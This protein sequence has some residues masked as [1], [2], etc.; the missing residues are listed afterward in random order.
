MWM[1]YLGLTKHFSIMHY[2]LAFINLYELWTSIFVFCEN[3]PRWNETIFVWNKPRWHH[4]LRGKLWDTMVYHEDSDMIKCD[5]WSDFQ[6]P[7]PT[8]FTK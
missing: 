6:Q 8:I 7:R 5:T 2:V 3:K 4:C 1:G